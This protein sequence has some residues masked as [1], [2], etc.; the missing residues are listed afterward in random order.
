MAIGYKETIINCP[1]TRESPLFANRSNKLRV[2]WDISNFKGASQA[3][4]YLCVTKCN[5]YVTKC[6]KCVT[7]LPKSSRCTNSTFAEN[8]TFSL[9][10]DPNALIVPSHSQRIPFLV[11]HALVSFLRFLH[12]K[13]GILGSQK[14]STTLVSKFLT[15]L[16]SKI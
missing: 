8:S 5:K 7:V 13:N 2:L 10:P 14:K 12:S 4:C 6:N 9:K 1:D 11:S 15:I 3:N 16:D